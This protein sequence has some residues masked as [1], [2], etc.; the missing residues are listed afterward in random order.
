MKGV[1]PVIRFQCEQCGKP[2]AVQDSSAGAVATCPRCKKKLRVP[3][4]EAAPTERGQDPED[5]LAFSRWGLFKGLLI[6]LL[7]N[8]FMFI[9]TVVIAILLP[10]AVL[11]QQFSFQMILGLGVGVL[12]ALAFGGIFL[13]S[14]PNWRLFVFSKIPSSSHYLVM[15]DRLVRYSRAGKVVEEVPFANIAEVRMLTR[16]SAVDPE[17]TAKVLGIDLRNL[18]DR[19]TILDR[20]FCLWS[21]KMH[22]HDLVMIDNFFEVPL[23][24]VY[25]KIKKRWEHWHETHPVST[26]DAPSASRHRREFIRKNQLLEYVFMGLGLVSLIGV[27]GLVCLVS[28]LGR[29]KQ[30]SKAVAP[31]P[32]DPKAVA[33]SP[34]DGARPPHQVAE[35]AKP[36]ERSGPASI[37]GLVAYWPLDEGQ[38]KAIKDASGNGSLGRIQ[39]GEWI[40]GVQGSAVRLGGEGDHIDLV[41]D[42]RLNFGAAASF[43]LA[44]WVATKSN[45]VI[46]SF[47]RGASPFP[48]IELS[49]RKGLLH[50]WVRDDTSGFGG[51]YVDGAS[52]NDGKWHHVALLRQ[53]DGTIELFLDGASQGRFKGESSGGPIT[54]D[55][56]TLGCD[57]FVM[58][59]QKQKA[60]G[61]LAG[62][63]DEFR[64]YNRPLA[65][66]EI[67]ALATRKQ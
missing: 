36:A 20:Q 43:T 66:A 1:T 61:Y 2:L 6:F 14:L 44:G 24:S 9:L 30:E 64:V 7:Y 13:A 50:G 55:L 19:R 11:Y 23:K 16:R 59:R 49:V 39:G 28:L 31:S 10:L 12:A 48:V 5:R 41:S 65:P 26:K 15:S 52:V 27:V 46:C 29:G 37:P 35:V 40:Q 63:V 18:D 8:P 38:G 60:P 57:R 3:E 54:T 45:G 4:S 42:Q 47:R 67:T 25:R 22:R 17:E 56:R 62:D 53:G 34:A 51:A 32:A 21:Q 58:L 33:I